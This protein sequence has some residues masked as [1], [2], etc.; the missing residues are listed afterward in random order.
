M[1]LTKAQ[2]IKNSKKENTCPC[3]GKLKFYDG[4]LGYEAFVCQKCGEH[5]GDLNEE[6][7]KKHLN[8]YLL[9]KRNN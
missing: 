4:A 3:G 9:G 1:V 2:M 5:W 6:D 7:Y 8:E